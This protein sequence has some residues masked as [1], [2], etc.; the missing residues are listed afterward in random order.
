MGITCGWKFVRQ[1][2]HR[3]LRG[4]RDPASLRYPRQ[5]V[6]AP[7]RR[8]RDRA[9][10]SICRRICQTLRSSSTPQKALIV[11]DGNSY[12]LKRSTYAQQRR[13]SHKKQYFASDSCLPSKNPGKTLQTIQR[14]SSTRARTFSVPMTGLLFIVQKPTGSQKGAVRRVCVPAAFSKFLSQVSA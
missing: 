8:K 6:Q 11:Q 2:A 4:P 5:T 1:L 7:G 3:G 13:T 9:V 14:S 12:W 10:V